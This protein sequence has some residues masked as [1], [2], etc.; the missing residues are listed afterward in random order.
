[1]AAPNTQPAITVSEKIKAYLRTLNG[2]ASVSGFVLCIITAILAIF[3][4][5]PELNV[6]GALGVL[7]I[8]VIIF[9][10]FTSISRTILRRVFKA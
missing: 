4:V 9:I 3:F 2:R 8:Y 1:M 7:T 10:F 6:M 5:L